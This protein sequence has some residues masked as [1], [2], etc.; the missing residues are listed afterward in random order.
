[1][2]SFIKGTCCLNVAVGGDGGIAENHLYV[3]I[4]LYHFTPHGK[5]PLGTPRRGWENNSKMDIQ[6]MGRGMN[7]TDLAQDK[8]RRRALVNAVI[9]LRVP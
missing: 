3:S 7:W 4:K 2:C 8:D 9:N 1:M 5:R 6:E